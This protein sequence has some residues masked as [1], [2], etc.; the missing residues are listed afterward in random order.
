ML[1]TAAE[2]PA[3]LPG[4]GSAWAYEV[5][6][7][8]VRIVADVRAGR[9]RL[10]SRNGNVVSAA[11]P[12]LAELAALPDRDCLLDGEVVV[13]RGGGP[14]FAALAERMHV[15]DS[16]RAQA[17]AA[18]AP[19]TFIVF[20]LL[21]L[22]GADLRERP[23]QARRT[24]LEHLASS[25]GLGRAVQLSPVYDDRD[26]LVQATIEQQLEGVV[27]KRRSSRYL[28]GGRTGDW[29][30]LA[31]KHVQSCVVGGW[32]WEVGGRD[33]IGALLL[34]V[35]ADPGDGDPGDGDPGDGDPRDGDSPRRLLF[36]GRAGS[37]LTAALE[38]RLR[39]LLTPLIV[40]DCPFESTVP[41]VD[42]R[43]AVWTRP[44]VVI[45]VRSLGRGDSGRLRQPV[46]RGLRDDL[47]PDDVRVE[48]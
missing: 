19:V 14:S 7:D 32:R 47:G 3:G 48:A 27:A 34:G 46:V 39:R 8:G 13:L 25:G 2:S 31:H 30:K 15:R 36:A 6:W 17:L 20:D 11:Y 44:Q 42:A 38:Q 35:Y 12:E 45:D 24:A 33:R 16:R 28:S 1:A 23:W 21:R 29:V 9:L 40:A 22:D 43:G 18:T 10:T 41:T 37:G 26:A 5:K 4:D